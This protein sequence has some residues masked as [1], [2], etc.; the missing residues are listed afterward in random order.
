MLVLEDCFFC[1][2]RGMSSANVFEYGLNLFFYRIALL[3][4]CGQGF[5]LMEILEVQNK[6]EMTTF[7]QELTCN[8]HLSKTDKPGRVVPQTKERKKGSG[9]YF[10]AVLFPGKTGKD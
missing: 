7:V 8:F 10:D 2:Q 1:G 4:V 5:K 9:G 6:Y 3:C